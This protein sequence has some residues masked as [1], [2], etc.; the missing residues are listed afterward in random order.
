V[1]ESKAAAL[2]RLGPTQRYYETLR[3]T[4]DEWLSRHTGSRHQAFRSILLLVPDVFTL[5]LRLAQDSR[6]P[7]LSRLKL[8]GLAVY[9]LSPIDINLDFLLPLG[10]LDDLALSVLVLEA[11]LRETPEYLLQEHWPGSEKTL[12]RLQ[13]LTSAFRAVRRSRGWVSRRGR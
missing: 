8:W 5:V 9:I 4:V 3:D 2:P 13:G 7:F 1:P 10:P 11:V 12:D 6:V